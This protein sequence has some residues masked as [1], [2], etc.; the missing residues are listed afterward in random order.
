[1]LNLTAQSMN[2]W[3]Y[4]HGPNLG[5]REAQVPGRWSV[6]NVTVVLERHGADTTSMALGGVRFLGPCGGELWASREKRDSEGSC[7][8][9]TNSHG[10]AS[11]PFVFHLLDILDLLVATTVPLLEALP[12]KLLEHISSYDFWGDH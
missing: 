10:P 11:T 4:P 1:M 7:W 5:F 6:K 9:D 2:M 8:H 3:P 12:S